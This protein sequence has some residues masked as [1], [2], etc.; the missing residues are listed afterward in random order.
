MVS[1]FRKALVR[2]R[3]RQVFDGV[4][5]GVGAIEPK[6]SNDLSGYNLH[7]HVVLD[8][9][10]DDVADVDDTWRAI[11]GGGRFSIDPNRPEPDDEEAL[12][13]YVSKTDEWDPSPGS[14][15]LARLDVVRT[16]IR[17]K[18]LVVVWGSA[19]APRRSKPQLLGLA[20]GQR[21]P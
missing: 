17:G 21:C 16:A 18:Q 13:T 7:A 11:T 14:L 10:E 15:D 9:G 1:S 12:A 3:R 5:G 19:R 20:Q 2:L 6:V 4:A 8:A